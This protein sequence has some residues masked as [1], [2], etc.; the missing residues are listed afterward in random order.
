MQT[1]GLK[2]KVLQGGIYLAL[3]QLFSVALSLISVL[4][5]ARILGPEQYGVVAIA[6]G[7]FY[8]LFWVSGLGLAVYLIRQPELPEDGA[9]QILAFYNTVGLA[10][11]GLLWF[12]TPIF[13]WWT[14]H[15][16]IS[17]VLRF[18]IPALWLGAISNVS[19]G[20]LERELRFAEV[21]LIE[22]LAQMANYLLAVPLVL[23]GWGYWGP[24][25]GLVV[26]FFILTVLAQHYYPIRWRWHWHWQFLKPALRYGLAYSGADWILSL[27]ALTV[28]LFVSRLLGVEAAGITSIALRLV[29]Q[30]AIL[31]LVVRRLSISALAKLVD[32]PS[33]TRS[34]ISQGMPYQVLLIGPICAAF[35]C[36]ATWIIPLMF[37]KAWIPSAQIFPFI[38]LAAII[39]TI[40]DLHASAL[41]AAGHNRQVAQFNAF[42]IGSLWL[43]ALLFLPILKL[44]GYGFAELLTIPS[45]LL[46]DRALAKLCGAPNYWNS[47]WLIVA[48]APALLF[49]PWVSPV[50]GISILLISYGLLFLLNA[51]VRSVPLELYAVWR[52]R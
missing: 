17:Q 28:P 51:N 10:F 12:A 22:T 29:D 27:K 25:A 7:I 41:S 18:L 33:S 3:R 2:I 6:S 48:T 19:I 9:E 42:Y 15:E 40:F 24:I 34:A 36:L 26:Q 50:I 5:I 14:G 45:Y 52:S 31:R 1:K 44:W 37:G 11:Y 16:E 23:M 39:G 35:S 49:G 21:G 30:L 20:M 4:V 43:A 8:F 13:G 47:V 32:N 38:A 46:M